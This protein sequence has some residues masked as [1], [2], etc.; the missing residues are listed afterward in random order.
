MDVCADSFPIKSRRIKRKCLC[1]DVFERII[2]YN[3]VDWIMVCNFGAVLR[4]GVE[5][6]PFYWLYENPVC[7]AVRLSGREYIMETLPKPANKKI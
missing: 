5:R 7:F 2:K 3:E 1:I 4:P 6:H